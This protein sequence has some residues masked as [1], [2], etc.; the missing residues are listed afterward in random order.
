MASSTLPARKPP[1]PSAVL[2]RSLQSAREAPE[3][4]RN[5]RLAAAP[6]GPTA[7]SI[8]AVAY[9]PAGG[10]ASPAD[11][12][13]QG[14]SE[15]DPFKKNGSFEFRNGE[16]IARFGRKV[17]TVRP[18]LTIAGQM[19]LIGKASRTV[20][21]KVKI[22]E[23]GK[24]RLVEVARSSGSNEVDQ[25]CRVAVYQWEFEPSRNAAGDPVPDVLMI[26]IV[27]R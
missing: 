25:P 23:H 16:L 18:R 7:P 20:I 13:P 9:P 1:L 19:D 21:L 14:D 11:P 17:K 10:T 15:S 24:V 12:A 4:P 26:P 27:F 3:D 5:E 8:N 22:D 6:A 2:Q